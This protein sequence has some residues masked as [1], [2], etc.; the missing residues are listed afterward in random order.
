MERKYLMS[1]LIFSTLLT[2]AH[3]DYTVTPQTDGSVKSIEGNALERRKGFL[4]EGIEVFPK[5]E[6]PADEGLPPSG[7]AFVDAQ[8]GRF[9]QRGTPSF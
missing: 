4:Q 9:A 3:G 8:R 1:V 6:A 2:I 7:L 5:G